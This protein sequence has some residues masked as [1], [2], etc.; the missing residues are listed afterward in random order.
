MRKEEQRA[1]GALAAAELAADRGH[2]HLVAIAHHQRAVDWTNEDAAPPARVNHH[3][4][5]PVENQ[6]LT[7]LQL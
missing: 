2:V 6:H 4:N 7:V 5:T 1:V 3:L